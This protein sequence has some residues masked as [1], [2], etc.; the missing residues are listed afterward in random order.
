MVRIYQHGDHHAIAE[1]FPR[2]VHE[3]ASGDYTLEQCRA[4]SDIE[5]N[6]EYWAKRCELKRPFV[7]IID[8]Q[9]AGFLELDTDGHIDC[10]YVNPDFRRS[11]VVTSL[12]RHAVSV[13]FSMNLPRVFV[14]ASI[15]AKPLFIKEGFEVI[16]E[17]SVEI[18]GVQLRNYDMELQNQ[19]AEQGV[20]LNR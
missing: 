17:K 6:P 12:V 14:E 2:A 15:C 9:V 4:W 11:G 8:S 3:I 1:I 13:A 5:P 10:A 18:D 7:A 20:A 19:Q 16:S